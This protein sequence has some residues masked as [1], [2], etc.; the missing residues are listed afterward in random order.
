MTPALSTA[1]LVGLA[2]LV[3]LAM[4]RGW[5]GLSRRSSA[6]LAELPA[7]PATDQLGEA[8]TDDL[9]ATYV[10]TTTAGDWLDR[11]AVHDLGV[12]SPAVVRVHEAGV[13][14]RRTGARDL[15]VPAA[16]LLAV[17]RTG[18]MAGKVVGGQGIVVLRWEAPGPGGTAVAVDTG[19]RLRRRSDSTTLTAAVDGLR[20]RR[21]AAPTSEEESR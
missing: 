21:P 11:L 1:L 6:I 3:L 7:E 8:L 18:G 4:W 2:A 5:R 19:L 10:S 20:Q 13:A 15:F 17:E 14:V 9:Q 16:A 12:R